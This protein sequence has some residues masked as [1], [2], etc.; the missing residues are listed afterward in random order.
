MKLRFKKLP[1]SGSVLVGVDGQTPKDIGKEEV[2]VEFN[3]SVTICDNPLNIC[4]CIVKIEK[5]V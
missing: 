5:E 2:V 1:G 3:E 4:R